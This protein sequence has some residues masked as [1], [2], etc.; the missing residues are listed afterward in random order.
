MLQGEKVYSTTLLERPNEQSR[1]MF[2]SLKGE[3]SKIRKG[4]YLILRHCT[5]GA[6]LGCRHANKPDA[7]HYP[8]LTFS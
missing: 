4:A 6:Y 5:T 7:F 2:E 8:L 3:E 1:F